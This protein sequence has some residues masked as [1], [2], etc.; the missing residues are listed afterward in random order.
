MLEDSAHSGPQNDSKDGPGQ[1]KQDI[2][3]ELETQ[4]I[5]QNPPW[6]PFL[7]LC[8]HSCLGVSALTALHNFKWHTFLKLTFNIK[9]FS[10]LDI[11]INIQLDV[12]PLCLFA[13]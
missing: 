2:E 5:H 1:Y 8:L 13:F 7:H 11:N 12:I 6:A 4:A 9:T 10:L 3:C